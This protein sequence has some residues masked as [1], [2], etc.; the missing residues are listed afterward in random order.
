[1]VWLPRELAGIVKVLLVKLPLALVVVVPALTLW[2]SK[3]KVI[4]LL[5]AK[6]VPLMVTVSPTA[7][8]VGVTVILGETV[9]LTSVE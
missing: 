1:M 3:E 4:E 7:P 9:K 2:A 8:V 6:P 5:A